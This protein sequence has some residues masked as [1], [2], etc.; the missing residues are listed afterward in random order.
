[1]VGHASDRPALSVFASL[2]VERALGLIGAVNW[3]LLGASVY[4]ATFLPG[5]AWRW[6]GAGL[7]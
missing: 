1:L 2:V 5:P 7:A 4:A 6:A 3:A